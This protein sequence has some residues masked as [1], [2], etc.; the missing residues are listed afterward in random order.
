MALGTFE[1]FELVGLVADERFRFPSEAG[2]LKI[3]CLVFGNFR[4]LDVCSFPRIL[5]VLD[6]K[7]LW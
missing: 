4:K 5:N 7:K 3:D 6:K 2:I 1:S